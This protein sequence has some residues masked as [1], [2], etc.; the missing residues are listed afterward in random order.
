MKTWLVG[1]AAHWFMREVEKENVHRKS[2]TISFYTNASSINW[3]RIEWLSLQI[4]ILDMVYT[5]NYENVML[6]HQMSWI[7]WRVEFVCIC[8]PQY[9]KFG[10]N[11]LWILLTNVDILITGLMIYGINKVG[12]SRY[13][14]E[15]KNKFDSDNKEPLSCFC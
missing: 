8:F 5:F 9:I 6:P 1:G 10:N 7:D 13:K 14:K 3:K 4:E 15:A 11:I 12:Y 2:N